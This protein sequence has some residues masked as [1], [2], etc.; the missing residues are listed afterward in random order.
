MVE[1]EARRASAV[2]LAAA[3]TASGLT[4]CDNE[5]GRVVP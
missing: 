3:A 5:S 2:A 1:A 4:F